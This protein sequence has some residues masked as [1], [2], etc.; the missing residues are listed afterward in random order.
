M[1]SYI[2]KL[3]R[4]QL[5]FDFYHHWPAYTIHHLGAITYDYQ[6]EELESQFE[7][8]YLCLQIGRT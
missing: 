8:D 1:N 6:L 7:P 5:G 4:H 3:K 2:Y